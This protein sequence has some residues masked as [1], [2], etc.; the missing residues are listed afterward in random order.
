MRTMVDMGMGRE[1]GALPPYIVKLNGTSSTA[2]VDV[3][4]GREVKFRRSFRSLVECMVPCCCGFHH[5]PAASSSSSSFSASDNIPA[6]SATSYN[7]ISSPPTSTSTSAALRVTGTFFGYRKGRKVSFCLQDQDRGR[8][9][10]PILLLD[11]AVPTS[12]LAREMQH[13]LLRIA[14]EC[15]H[16]SLNLKHKAS[17]EPSSAA[18]GLFDVPAWSM[19][20]NGRKVGFAL[21]RHLTV[22]DIT[23]LDLMRSVS[24]GAGV[25][26]LHGDL[27]YLRAT[28]DRVVGSRDS[29]SFHMIN[30]DGTSA[31]ELSIFFLRS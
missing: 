28:F 9:A 6:D 29:E 12:Y 1:R 26:P 5:H 16:R 8:S 15:D 17:D 19:Y 10:A 20:C 14:L 27:L 31:Q 21:R 4:C 30:P 23:V 3:D 25:L 2:L 22:S 24:V 11:L 18:S 13:G 7:Y